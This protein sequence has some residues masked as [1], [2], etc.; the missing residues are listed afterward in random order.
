MTEA[1]RVTLAVELENRMHAPAARAYLFAGRAVYHA[2]VTGRELRFEGV[3]LG[4][5][6]EWVGLMIEAQ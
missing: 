5:D 2:D 3:A 6:V 1:S 4:E